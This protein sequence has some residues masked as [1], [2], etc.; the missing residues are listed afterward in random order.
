MFTLSNG[1]MVASFFCMLFKMRNV[2]S[3]YSMFKRIR[4]I[5]LYFYYQQIW[6]KTKNRI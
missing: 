2:T 1:C 5:I 3:Y 4:L 6:A